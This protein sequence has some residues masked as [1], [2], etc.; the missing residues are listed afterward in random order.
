MKAVVM[1]GGEGTR[2]R[3]LTN[4]QPKPMVPIVNKPCMGHIIDLLKKHGITDIIA[5]VAFLPQNIRGY[6]GDGSS[7]G[8][9]LNYSVEETPLGTAGS[10]RNAAEY[11]DDTFLVISGDALTNINLTKLVAYHHNVKTLATLALYSLPNPTEYGVITINNQGQITRFQEK[12]GRGSVMS[13]HVNTGIYVLEP[14]VFD[15]IPAGQSYDF[16]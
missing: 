2:L 12:P 16:G 15:Y 3:P 6:F 4:N 9:S 10:V 7:L 13:D 1:A 14:G 5:T 11:L 8:V